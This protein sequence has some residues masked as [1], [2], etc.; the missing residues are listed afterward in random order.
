MSTS[1][2]TPYRVNSVLNDF[3]CLPRLA[4][5]IDL[6]LNIVTGRAI[7]THGLLLFFH[8]TYIIAKWQFLV[9]L[10]LLRK[11]NT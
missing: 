6:A 10:F 11:N 4:S 8:Y 1:G 5:A 3:G 9:N 2:R 7:I